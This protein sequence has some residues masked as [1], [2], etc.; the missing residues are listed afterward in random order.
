MGETEMKF[1]RMLKE[2]VL[3]PFSYHLLSDTL[4]RIIF[5]FV[6]IQTNKKSTLVF[7]EPEVHSFPPYIK[8]LAEKIA[9]DNN[10]QYFVSTHNIDFLL[11]LLSKTPKQDIAIFLTYMKN[12][13]TGVKLLNDE[14]IKNILDLKIDLF[15]NINKFLPKK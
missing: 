8:F 10:N 1:G 5:Y 6:A 13:Q 9:L 4:Q 3:C 11:S 15:F 14:N 7:E 12:Y 2:D